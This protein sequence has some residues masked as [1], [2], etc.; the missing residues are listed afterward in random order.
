MFKKIN[1]LLIIIGMFCLTLINCKPHA[2][3][4]ELLRILALRV[5]T[6][7]KTAT[8][9]WSTNLPSRGF[10]EFGL[11][12]G[13]GNWIED[14]LVNVYHETKLSGLTPNKKYYF[15]LRAESESG[16][17]VISDT[18]NFTTE[19][20]DDNAAPIL[21][22]IRVSFSTGNTLTFVWETDEPADSCVNYNTNINDLK[23]N[24]CN[25]S[26]VNV[27]DITVD[28]LNVNT[29]YYYSVSS[30]DKAGNSQTSIIYQARTSYENDSHAEQFII[31]EILPFNQRMSNDIYST[32]LIIKTSRPISGYVKFG[33]KSGSYNKQINI[34]APRSTETTIILPDLKENHIYYYKLYLKDALNKTIETQEYSFSTLPKNILKNNGRVIS[35]DYEPANPDQ[36]FDS[37]G[38]TN[39]QEKIYGTDPV[40]SDTDGD[41]LV[42]GTEIAKGTNPLNGIAE[43]VKIQ[44][45]KA[46]AYGK[47]RIKSLAEEQNL[48]KELR[49]KLEQSFGGKIPKNNQHWYI[50]VNA[51]VY[52][53]Y[54]AEAI[55]KAIKFGGK[56]VH[57]SIPFSAWKNSLDYQNYI[58]R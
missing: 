38:L 45:D 54:P 51:Y 50:L 8:I 41:G 13:F 52:G 55:A 37:D 58:N 23:Y 1:I 31:Y 12:N 53:G 14:N 26:M 36:D 3:A 25:G 28:K 47:A 22:K 42:D 33:E 9:I 34:Q 15:R 17:S 20:L 18:Y 49:S 21:K 32:D 43:Q 39:G 10:F 30:K 29:L 6:T 2:N 40:K 48:A 46:F 4:D 35:D 56:T 7:D 11:T 44:T 27:H 57:P 19:N 5:S 24:R 16:Q